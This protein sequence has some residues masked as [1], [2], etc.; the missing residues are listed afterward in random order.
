MSR[1]QCEQ[2]EQKMKECIPGVGKYRPKFEYGKISK[3]QIKFSEEGKE[4]YVRSRNFL[5][6]PRFHQDYNSVV[7]LFERPS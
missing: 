2:Y 4:E 5:M 3:P 7:N 1:E 6:L